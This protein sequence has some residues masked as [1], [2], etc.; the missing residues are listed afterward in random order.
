MTAG[1]PFLQ[2]LDAAAEAASTAEQLYRRQA[3]EEIRRLEQ[4]RAFAFRRANLMRA[5][6][7]ALAGAENA[8]AA[9]GAGWVALCAGLG[10]PPEG[11]AYA[12]LR[13]R[14]RPVAAALFADATA[15]G[16]TA[17]AL[18]AFERWYAETYG[19]PFWTLFEQPVTETPLVDF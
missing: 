10:W 19:R 18:E 1:P 4:E 11:E 7:R 17:A 15:G 5:V 12:P 2:A 8:E 14:F 9:A 6:A 13:S 3:A 16:Q